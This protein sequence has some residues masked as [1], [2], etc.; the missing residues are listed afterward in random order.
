MSGIIF[1]KT[2]DLD[3][4]TAFYRERLRFEDWLAQEDCVILRHGNLLLGF[5]QRDQVDTAGL[6]TVFCPS[7]KE[8]DDYYD[9]LG[10]VAENRPRRNDKYNIYHFFGKDPDGRTFEVQY[11]LNPVSRYL[12]G[13]ELLFTRR[14]V[15]HFL[16]EPVPE[17]LLMKVIDLSRFA[18]TSR[19]TQGYY[20]KMI[21]DP[22]LLKRLSLLRGSSTAPLAQAPQAVAVCSDPGKSRRHI[23]D[24]CIA[25]YHFLLA[26]WHY[27]LGTCWIAAM[28]SPEVKSLLNL[29]EAHYVATITPFGFPA[30]PAPATPVRRELNWFLHD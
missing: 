2:G 12:S 11:F 20:F 19:N 25:A 10:D 21:D 22:N 9:S 24:G 18:P 26:A 7:Q 8:V 4:I 29:P 27:G 3:Q 14:S 15:R 17:Q 28:D 1:V 5:C 13:D 30:S 23:Q 6:I 16:S